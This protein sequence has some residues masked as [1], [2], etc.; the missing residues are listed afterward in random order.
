[1]TIQI[2]DEERRLWKRLQEAR[3]KL[4]EAWDRFDERPKSDY[5]AA[6]DEFIVAESAV[7][8]KWNRSRGDE[9]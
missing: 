8:E 3:R 6:V 4:D 7:H 1:M 2:D 9:S 5:D